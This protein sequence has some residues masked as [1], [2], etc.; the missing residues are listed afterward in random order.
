MRRCLFAIVVAVAAAASADV[1]PPPASRADAPPPG[2]AKWAQRWANA[3]PP[4][5]YVAE[6]WSADLDD[7][8]KS[9]AVAIVYVDGADYCVYLVETARGA[10]F[11]IKFQIE[12]RTQRAHYGRRDGEPSATI[13]F[14]RTRERAIDHF[15]GMHHGGEEMWIAIRGDAPVMIRYESSAFSVDRDGEQTD[16][17]HTICDWDRACRAKQARRPCTGAPPQSDPEYE[18]G[19]CYPKPIGDYFEL[20]PIE[21]RPR[22]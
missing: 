5:S 17:E 20:L 16:S 3:G 14:A 2:F 4:G 18:P 22:R 7:D 9:D 15:Q 10:R 6:W 11:A 1:A 8:G 19:H 13:P 21:A 12:G